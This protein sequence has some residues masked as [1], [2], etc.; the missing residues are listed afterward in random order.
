MSVL[1]NFIDTLTVYWFMLLLATIISVLINLMRSRKYGYSKFLS[2]ILTVTLILCGCI[3]AKIL[4]VL[5]NPLKEF[6][7]LNGMSFFGSVFFIPLGM[8]LISFAIKKDILCCADF[9]SPSVPLVLAFMRIGCY[10][11]SCCGGKELMFYGRHVR[12]PAQLIECFFDLIIFILLLKIDSSEHSKGMLYPIFM[13]SYSFI[14]FF[15]E[16]IRD[17]EKV[18]FNFTQGQILSVVTFLFGISFLIILKRR[19]SYDKC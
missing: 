11:S 13:I 12:P 10:F 9:Y 17:N 2:I 8:G 4:Y 5:E 1:K 3:G 19:Y 7:V 15:M 6:S 16:F 14:R 18:F